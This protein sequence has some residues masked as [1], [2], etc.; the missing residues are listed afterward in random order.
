MTKEDLLKLLDEN[1]V[2][3]FQVVQELHWKTYGLF[4]NKY[5]YWFSYRCDALG[6]T[7]G[8]K[9]RI[10]G[11]DMTVYALG[12]LTGLDTDSL[13][14]WQKE[15]EGI[16][17]DRSEKKNFHNTY[18]RGSVCFNLDFRDGQFRRDRLFCNCDEIAFRTYLEDES[19]FIIQWSPA[20]M[21][22]EL[23]NDRGDKRNYKIADLPGKKGIYDYRSLGNSA[24]GRLREISEYYSQIGFG[25]SEIQ[26]QRIVES[27]ANGYVAEGAMNSTRAPDPESIEDPIDFQDIPG[28]A[29]LTCI[30]RVIP[31]LIAA[32]SCMS[33]HDVRKDRSQIEEYIASWIAQFEEDGEVPI[34]RENLQKMVDLTIGRVY[35][36]LGDST[37]K[38]IGLF[39]SIRKCI[40]DWGYDIHDR[41]ITLVE[42]SL[43]L[44]SCVNLRMLVKFY[45]FGAMCGVTK[46]EINDLFEDWE[47]I[48]EINSM[49]RYPDVDDFTWQSFNS[50][51][52]NTSHDQQYTSSDYHTH[53]MHNC[54]SILELEDGASLNEVKKAFKKLSMKFHPDVIAGKELDEAFVEFATMKFQQIN[55]AY[56]YLVA[57]LSD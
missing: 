36:A 50:Q 19:R 43:A 8:S 13:V 3:P 21:W 26:I 16:P 10:D 51:Q 49:Q 40:E 45:Q 41:C 57:H 6:I 48:R 56:E 12:R 1:A 4:N 31:A 30:C 38:D 14:D 20:S 5:E 18:R 24:P 39:R 27:I 42:L 37:S 32:V 44:T 9:N 52:E 22:I 17:A 54:Y 25:F 29:Y 28:P 15:H 55:E 2:G 33:G 53:D 7:W 11:I 47:I 46:P 23:T 34:T 35:D